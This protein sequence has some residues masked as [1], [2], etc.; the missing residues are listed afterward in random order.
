MLPSESCSDLCKTRAI[1]RSEG[2]QGKSERRERQLSILVV[3]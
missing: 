1:R 3:N 2:R